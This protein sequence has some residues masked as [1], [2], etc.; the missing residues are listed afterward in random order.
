MCCKRHHAGLGSSTCK[1]TI[2]LF[3]AM[4]SVGR[5]ALMICNAPLL[6]LLRTKLSCLYEVI[7]GAEDSLE[8]A[9]N[10]SGT[11]S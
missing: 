5:D 2:K 8:D 4:A 11:L 6:G 7:K 10:I 3:R 9:S 1:G